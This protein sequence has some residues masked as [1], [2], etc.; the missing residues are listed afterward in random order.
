MYYVKI[1]CRKIFAENRIEKLEKRNI[2]LEAELARQKKVLEDK[3][4]EHEN[5]R[6]ELIQLRNYIYKNS[7]MEEEPDN[8]IF[9]FERMRKFWLEQSVVMIGGHENWQQKIRTAFPKWKYITA[10]QASFSPEIISDKQYI[11]C[12][13]DVLAHSV[14]YKVIANR[15]ANQILFYT[16]GRNVEKFLIELDRQ[17]DY[18]KQ[19]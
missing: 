9:D 4:R 5:E 12:N 18:F 7:E 11:I 14:Y 10:G 3:N 15:N 17:V 2:E 13:T 1:L 19:L 6:I 8:K 16:H